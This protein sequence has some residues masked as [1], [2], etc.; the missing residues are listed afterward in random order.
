MTPN[1][2]Y[3]VALEAVEALM[4]RVDHATKKKRLYLLWLAY[5]NRRI[6]RH[7]IESAYR[8]LGID[9]WYDSE[10]SFLANIVQDLSKNKDLFEGDCRAGWRLTWEGRSRA[11][12]EFKQLAI[13][14]VKWLEPKTGWPS[15]VC[16]HLITSIA[17][18]V[19]TDRV[20]SYKIGI[21]GDPA[22]R[23]SYYRGFEEMQVV[24]RTQS[25]RNVRRIEKE[26]V[27]A[28]LDRERNENWTGGGGGGPAGPSLYLYVV[29]N[30]PKG[31]R[32]LPLFVFE[33]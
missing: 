6:Q 20:T 15:R 27:A 9:K 14:E 30:R 4:R 31:A 21:T 32:Q 12:R 3:T 19:R 7:K 33:N 18:R 22:L 28:H 25:K 29:M 5:P 16:D 17:Q 8:A 2:T 10:T 1:Y 24:Y 26:L 11:E 13:P 23:A